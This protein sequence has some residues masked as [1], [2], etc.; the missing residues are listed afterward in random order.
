MDLLSKSHEVRERD[1]KHRPVPFV[2]KCSKRAN[3][4]KIGFS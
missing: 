1:P 4:P 2:A 3:A